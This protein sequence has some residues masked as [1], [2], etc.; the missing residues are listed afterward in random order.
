MV[1]VRVGEDHGIDFSSRH[2][3]LF[4]VAQPPL[5][6]PLEHAAVNQDLHAAFAGSVGFRVD[7]VFGS[8]YSAGGAEKLQIGHSLPSTSEFAGADYFILSSKLTLL[9]S[10]QVL[11][12]CFMASARPIRPYFWTLFCRP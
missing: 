3:G 8:S 4:P 10:T 7:E 2:R 6:L 9:L 11:G 12:S 5:F 1:E